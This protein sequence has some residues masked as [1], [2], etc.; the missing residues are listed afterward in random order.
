MAP[1]S[2]VKRKA[3][4]LPDRRPG[5]EEAENKF[6]HWTPFAPTSRPC[7][8]SASLPLAPGNAGVNDGARPSSSVS[9][10]TSGT[11]GQGESV[12]SGEP[13]PSVLTSY[14]F[15]LF[16]FLIVGSLITEFGMRI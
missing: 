7:P 10:P 8:S 14:L 15:V 9:G 6:C 11:E 1:K 2:A 5:K 4:S 3:S 12:T 13:S 16:Y